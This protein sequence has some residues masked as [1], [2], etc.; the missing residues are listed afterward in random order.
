MR[1]EDFRISKIGEVTTG[2]GQSGTA[3][4]IEHM[5]Y[6]VST[7]PIVETIEFKRSKNGNVHL[8]ITSNAPDYSAYRERGTYKRNRR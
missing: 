7:R 8:V 6:L 4:V 1:I 3:R 2:Y 5:K